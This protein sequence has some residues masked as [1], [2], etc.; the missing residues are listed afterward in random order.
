MGSPT[1]GLFAGMFSYF[2]Y[3]C[4][5]YGGDEAIVLWDFDVGVEAPPVAKFYFSR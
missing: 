4:N 3:F 2:F 1:A 5:L